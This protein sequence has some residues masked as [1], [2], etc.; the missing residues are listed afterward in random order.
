MMSELFAA[1]AIDAAWRGQAPKLPTAGTSR[2]PDRL[3]EVA[4][5]LE[6]V[7]IG[8]M[9]Q[10]MFTNTQAE[11][12]F[13]GGLAEE[14]WQSMLAAEF[15]KAIAGGGGIGLADAVVRQLLS[16]Q[17]AAGDGTEGATR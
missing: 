12:P 8:Q 7:F 15:G 10:P 17:E 1:P 3:R 9:L 4:T 13:G 11:S 6:A 2:S 14:M 16:V 5:E